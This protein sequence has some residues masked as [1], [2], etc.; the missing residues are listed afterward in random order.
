M[1]EAPLRGLDNGGTI[2]L[3]GR[4]RPVPGRQRHRAPVR[5]LSLLLPKRRLG[6]TSHRP[7]S[8][9]RPRAVL[10]SRTRRRHNPHTPSPHRPR[11]ARPRCSPPRTT[12]TSLKD[13]PLNYI[14][15]TLSVFPDPGHASPSWFAANGPPAG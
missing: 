4:R 9:R 13:A 12:R 1:A 3:G 11:T 7:R 10:I 5:L 6:R 2:R 15:P 8:S 14:Q